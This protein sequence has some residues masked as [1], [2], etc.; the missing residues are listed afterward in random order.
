MFEQLIA[1]LQNAVKG[2]KIEVNNKTFTTR[3]VF[4]IAPR[5]LSKSLET[6]TLQSIVDYFGSSI[7][8]AGTTDE[9]FVIHIASPSRVDI[10][11]FLDEDNQREARL[12]AKYEGHNFKFGSLY[13]QAEFITML[14]SQ[15]VPSDTRE[16]LQRFVGALTDESSLKLEDDGVSQKTVAKTGITTLSVVENN[17]PLVLAPF[18]TFPEIDQPEGEFILR[19]HRRDGDVPKISLHESDNQAWKLEAI[20]RIA[21]WLKKQKVKVPILA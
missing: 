3:P 11:L 19:L 7:D 1:E 16:Q 17:K 20:N 4:E 13:D 21:E 14:R 5:R 10:L 15:F 6:A 18:R 2:E 12:S 9:A 8:A